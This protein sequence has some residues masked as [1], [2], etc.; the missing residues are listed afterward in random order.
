MYE[1]QEPSESKTINWPPQLPAEG[2]LWILA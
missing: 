1:V 2:L